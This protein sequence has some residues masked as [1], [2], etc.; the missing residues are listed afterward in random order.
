MILSEYLRDNCEPMISEAVSLKDFDKAVQLISSI[1]KRKKVYTLKQLRNLSV[2]G[3]KKLGLVVWTDNNQAACFVW[4][5]GHNAEIE[6]VLFTKNFDEMNVAWVNN[7][8]F[9]WDV[10]VTANGT[11]TFQM[12]KMVR[13]VLLG[14]VPMD[15]KSIRASISSAQM[16]EDNVFS[17]EPIN[18][19]KIRDLEKYKMRIYM[20]LRAAKRKGADNIDQL[21]A[22]FDGVK[23]QL[24]AARTEIRNKVPSQ[25][26]TEPD[27]ENI[28]NIFQDTL[29]ATPE[30]RFEDMEAYIGD[31]IRGIRPLALLCG[32]PGVGKTFRTTEA[33][34]R[35]GKVKDKDYKLLKA[36]CTPASLYMA[37]HDY[38]NQGQLIVMD[39]C[40]NVFKDADSI[41]L[42]KAAFDSSD[43]RWVTW[44]TA[45][46]IPMDAELAETCD[47]AYFNPETD[48]WYYPK[49]FEFK[50]GGIIIT[51]FSAGQIDTAIRNR[52]LICDLDFTPQ[53]TIDYIRNLAPKI[54]AST[55]SEEAKEMSLD[56]LQHLVDI[57]APVELSIRSFTLCAGI[58]D[59]KESPMASKK[60]RINEQMRLQALRGGKKY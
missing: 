34:K 2:N 5:L 32:A 39:D 14:E 15:A 12:C 44:E 29:R 10:E 31:V 50:G 40:D 18:E 37:L 35:M 41:N 6:S 8:P 58:F 36:K 22:Q 38:K 57:K 49:Q 9:V 59:D 46:P 1:F 26:E 54:A 23:A 51:N 52:A 3:Q 13:K 56:Y 47:D 25:L 53:E 20:Q 43:E 33:L 55:L 27:I 30:E 24:S 19:D 7:E 17:E 16:F 21:Q 48:R 60:R 4:S 45:R 42:L 11:N 28:E